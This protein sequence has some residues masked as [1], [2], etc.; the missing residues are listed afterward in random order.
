MVRGGGAIAV[1]VATSFSGRSLGG[2]EVCKKILED[3]NEEDEK[4]R[5][6]ENS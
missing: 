1:E 3:L 4:R 5:S 6:S 2:I